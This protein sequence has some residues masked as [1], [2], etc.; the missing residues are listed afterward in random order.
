[1]Q[2]VIGLALVLAAVALG[3]YAGFWWA[4][5]GGIVG[6]IDAVRAPEVIPM[7]VAINV[8]KVVFATPLGMLCGATLALPGAALLDK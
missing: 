2:K 5:V 3:L 8:A 4:F 1:M 7:D 6:F